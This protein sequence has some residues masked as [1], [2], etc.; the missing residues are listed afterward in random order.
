MA[1]PFEPGHV[2]YG[3][4]FPLYTAPWPYPVR[5]ASPPDDYQRR[6]DELREQVGDLLRRMSAPPAPQDP[7]ERLR[8][9]LEEEMRKMVDAVIARL[10]EGK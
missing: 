10:K 1:N 4:G 5:P 2:V 7:S 6:L 3:C 8:P 9:I